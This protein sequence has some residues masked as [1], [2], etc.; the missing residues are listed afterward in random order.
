MSS[1]GYRAGPA[2]YCSSETFSIQ[3]TGDPFWL[4]WIAMWLIAADDVAPCQWRTF[5]GHQM[6]SPA[7]NSSTGPPSIWVQPTPEVTTS[8]CPSGCLCQAVRAPGSKATRAAPTCDGPFAS[9]SGVMVALPVKF[10][11]GPGVAGRLLLRLISICP[12]PWDDWLGGCACCAC[13]FCCSGAQASRES[14]TV[15]VSAF[16]IDCLLRD[17]GRGKT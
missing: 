12:A 16:F 6:T 13:W 11:A 10:S 5:G 4:S 15:N 9:N 8:R 14:G 3:V 1:D 17:A 7:P 2:R